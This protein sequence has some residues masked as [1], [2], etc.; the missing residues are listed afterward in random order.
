MLVHSP[1][2]ACAPMCEECG[3]REK[4]RKGRKGRQAGRPLLRLW[5]SLLL[6]L[7]L[8][9]QSFIE[10]KTTQQAILASAADAHDGGGGRE[11]G[12]RQRRKT[13]PSKRHR[14][15]AAFVILALFVRVQR[16]S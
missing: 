10:P 4:G 15:L 8:R 5:L 12:G 2:C 11:K 1:E 16:G 6:L 9:L 13:K 3:A 7:R 14:P